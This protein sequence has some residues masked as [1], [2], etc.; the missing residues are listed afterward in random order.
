MRPRLQKRRRRVGGPLSFN[1]DSA[2]SSGLGPELCEP[3][4][5]APHLRTDPLDGLT[6]KSV[7]VQFAKGDNTV[8][9]PTATSLI[10][11][12]AL[13]DRATYFRNDLAFATIPGYT[14]TNPHTFLTNLTGA[15]APLAAAAQ[16][17]AALFLASGG[18]T[19]IDPDGAGPYFETPIA[20]PLPETLNFLP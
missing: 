19:T 11:A 4:A 8:P 3:V 2:R 6:A 16:Q 12:G 13:T 14:V 17:Q 10:R 1:E 15:S 18:T 9:N 5:Y 7:L 20:G